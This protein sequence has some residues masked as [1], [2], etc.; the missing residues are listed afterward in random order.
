MPSKS[1]VEILQSGPTF[2][3]G[4]RK[5]QPEKQAPPKAAGTERVEEFIFGDEENS[6]SAN[7]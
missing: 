6:P 1:E 4:E 5:T 7:K 2:V 3:K